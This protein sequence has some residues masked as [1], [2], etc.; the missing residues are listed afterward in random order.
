MIVVNER[1]NDAGAVRLLVTV[2]DFLKSYGFRDWLFEYED[3]NF[4]KV[5]DQLKLAVDMLE[6]IS[7][8]G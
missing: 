3:K 4:R 5:Y 1:H 6:K 8:M 7:E 2:F